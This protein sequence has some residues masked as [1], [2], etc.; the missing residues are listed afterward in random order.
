MSRLNGQTQRLTLS[1]QMGL[2]EDF[3][4]GARTHAIGERTQTRFTFRRLR[5]KEVGH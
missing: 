1:K 4:D 3:V 2:T 5:G